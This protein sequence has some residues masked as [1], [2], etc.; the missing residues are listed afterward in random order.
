MH[1]ISINNQAMK[2]KDF[3]KSLGMLG[4]T[5]P[6]LGFDSLSDPMDE[7]SNNDLL[8]SDCGVS[9]SEI[10]GPYPD[11]YSTSFF[12]ETSRTTKLTNFIFSGKT[13]L[14]SKQYKKNRLIN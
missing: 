3:L 5:L 8:A 12:I 4:A 7:P 2:R 13:I 1:K 9:P 10:A 14:N 11:I 6:V